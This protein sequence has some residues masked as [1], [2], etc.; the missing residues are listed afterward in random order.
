M[1]VFCCAQEGRPWGKVAVIGGRRVPIE[2]ACA[3]CLSTKKAGFGAFTWE[4]VVN[5]S[6]AA[7]SLLQDSEMPTWSGKVVAS[8]NGETQRC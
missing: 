5:F 2:S 7:Q 6:M 1:A 4:E 8:G 3:D